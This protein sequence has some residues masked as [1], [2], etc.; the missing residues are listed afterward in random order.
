IWRDFILI[1]TKLINDY[2]LNL[3][4][5]LLI[6]HVVLLLCEINKNVYIRSSSLVFT[7]SKLAVSSTLRQ[8]TSRLICR[9]SP[10]KTFP[11]P[12]S[13]KVPTPLLISNSIDCVQRTGAETCLYNAS[14]KAPASLVTPA[15][16]L[17][18]TG[19]CAFAN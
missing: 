1:H 2:L 16:A 15:S 9:I 12:T 18:T 11:G 17:V 19:T 13:T 14:L 4:L 7:D 6:G 3:I 10:V 5:D 8:V